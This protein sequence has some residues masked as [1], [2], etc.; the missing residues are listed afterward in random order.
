VLFD[1]KD[2]TLAFAEFIEHEARSG[3]RQSVAAGA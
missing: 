1:R 2:V 3:R